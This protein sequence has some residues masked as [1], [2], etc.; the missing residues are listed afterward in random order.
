MSNS[1]EDVKRIVSEMTVP[2]LYERAQTSLAM[3]KSEIWA[4]RTYLENRKQLLQLEIVQ[5]DD[6]LAKASLQTDSWYDTIVAERDFCRI[7]QRART[8]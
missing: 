4:L 1:L 3:A 2:E 5:I 6:V 7:Q 8:S